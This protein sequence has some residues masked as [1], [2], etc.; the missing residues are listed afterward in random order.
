MVVAVKQ[1]IWFKTMTHQLS[2][3]HLL[4]G[5]VAIAEKSKNI[6]KSFNFHLSKL[7]TRRTT[8]ITSNANP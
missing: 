5:T 2:D 4:V 1:E 6:G 3:Y 8:I 7:L